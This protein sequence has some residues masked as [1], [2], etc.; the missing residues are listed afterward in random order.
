MSDGKWLK[1]LGGVN[2][3]GFYLRTAKATAFLPKGIIVYCIMDD[4]YEFRV[5]TTQ[6]Y[7][8]V[9]EFIFEADMKHYFEIYV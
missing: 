1:G 2:L 6:V 8:G 3:N 4:D 7:N 9:Q 5:R